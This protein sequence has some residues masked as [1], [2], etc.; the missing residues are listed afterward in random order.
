MVA[1]IDA[2]LCIISISVEMSSSGVWLSIVANFHTPHAIANNSREDGS[3]IWFNE[4]SPNDPQN[5]HSQYNQSDGDE[6]LTPIT[7]HPVV[8]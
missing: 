6:K 5:N 7:H 4:L 1:N 3:S 8:C 2:M